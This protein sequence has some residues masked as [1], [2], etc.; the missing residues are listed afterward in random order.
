MIVWEDS[1]NNSDENL[2]THTDVYYQEIANGDFLYSQ[3]GIAVCDAYHIQT[4][5]K[6][7]LYSQNES[8]QF[9]N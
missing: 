7:A 6:I 5:P 3:N 8:D 1:R 4:E 9:I 2:Q